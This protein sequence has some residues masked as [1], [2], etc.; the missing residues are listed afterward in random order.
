ML[1]KAEETLKCRECGCSMYPLPG[2]IQSIYVCSKCGFSADDE[3]CKEQEAL[4][5]QCSNDQPVGIKNLLNDQFM[6]KYTHFPNLGTFIDN[7]KLLKKE[8][9]LSN[10]ETITNLPKRKWDLYIK[11]NTCFHS[12]DEMFEKAVGVYLKL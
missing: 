11:I 1:S 9:Y 12:W 7:C 4:S 5:K 2:S 8:D 6:K 10:F 3:Y